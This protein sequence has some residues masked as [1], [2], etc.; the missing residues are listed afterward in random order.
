MKPDETHLLIVIQDDNG[1]G[2]SDSDN[3]NDNE[4]WD[5]NFVMCLYSSFSEWLFDGIVLLSVCNGW[6]WSI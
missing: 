6:D 2:L 5:C 4:N 3:D 1:L